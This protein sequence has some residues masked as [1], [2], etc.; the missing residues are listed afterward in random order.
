MSEAM[1]K[2]LII[3]GPGE[4]ER[5]KIPENAQFWSVDIAHGKGVLEVRYKVFPIMHAGQSWPVGYALAL[6]GTA[7]EE[8]CALWKSKKGH[9]ND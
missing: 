4:D 1:E 7:P 8:V 2:A 3:N 9:N 6:P 5:V